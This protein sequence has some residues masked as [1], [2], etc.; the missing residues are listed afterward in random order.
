VRD[1]QAELQ[2]EIAAGSEHFGACEE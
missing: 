1:L 2:K